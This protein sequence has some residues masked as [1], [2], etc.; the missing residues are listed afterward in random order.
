MW[1]VAKRAGVDQ[2]CDPDQIQAR[3]AR[4]RLAIM[5]EPGCVAREIGGGP[6]QANGVA[7]RQR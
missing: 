1:I 6:A 2:I 4:C 3:R 5:I 7:G